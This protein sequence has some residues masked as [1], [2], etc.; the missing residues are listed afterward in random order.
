MVLRLLS[1]KPTAAPVCRVANHQRVWRVR[2]EA[3]LLVEVRHDCRTTD[4]QQPSGRYP[5]RLKGPVI[6][7]PDQLWTA[8][9]TS[10]RLPR[11]FV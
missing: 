3:S 1:G 8:D 10:S 6:A 11:E 5:N 4:S 2:R 7:R 9:S